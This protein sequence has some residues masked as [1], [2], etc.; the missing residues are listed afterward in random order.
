MPLGR[1]AFAELIGAGAV[2]VGFGDEIPVRFESLQDDGRAQ[3]FL[4]VPE[5]EVRAHQDEGGVVNWVLPGPRRLS[6]YTFGTP[7]NPISLPGHWIDLAEG[8]VQELLQQFPL[9]AGVPMEMRGTND[10]GTRFTQTTEPTPF[11]DDFQTT[12]G[13]L[14][15]TY[16]D[17]QPKDRTAEPAPET[18][19]PSRDDVALSSTFTDPAGNEYELQLTQVA[20]RPFPNYES[21]GGVVTLRDLHGITGTGTPLMPRMFNYGAFWGF[22]DL[23]INGEVADTNRAVHFMSTEMVRKS[24]YGLAFTPELPLDEDTAYTG[25]PHHTHGILPPVK[26]TGDGPQYDPVPTAFE[27]PNGETQPF[28]HIMY[29]RDVV[30]EIVVRGGSTGENGTGASGDGGGGNRTDG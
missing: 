19:G 30:D 18:Q 11:G 14:D 8:P 29:D 5:V 6:R 22:C 1:R 21:G 25:Y 26:L 3:G 15:I 28:I 2:G 17:R 24:D 27:L 20:P 16:V 12:G 4:D 10:D 9:P 13:Q 23:V 7:E